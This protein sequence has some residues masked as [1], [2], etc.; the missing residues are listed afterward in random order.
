MV[1]SWLIPHIKI[2]NPSGPRRTKPHHNVKVADHGGL[3]VDMRLNFSFSVSDLCCLS[4]G[5]V[6]LICLVVCSFTGDAD[7]V[8]QCTTFKID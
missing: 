7:W 5:M 1:C 4:L 6:N 3:R 8:T 2:R